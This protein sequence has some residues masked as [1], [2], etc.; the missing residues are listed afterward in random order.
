EAIASDLTKSL[1]SP[2]RNFTMGE[3]SSC[4]CQRCGKP[5]RKRMPHGQ[6]SV[7]AKCF[8]CGADYQLSLRDDGNV[9]WEAQVEELTCSGQGCEAPLLNW[10]DEIKVGTW[11]KCSGCDRRYGIAYGI[12]P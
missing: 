8:S 4:D 3:F 9:H 11:W 5:I 12:A 1:N 10:R 7:E 6:A 2:I